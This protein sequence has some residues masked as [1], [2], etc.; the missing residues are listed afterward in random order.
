V[1]ARKPPLYRAR[2][3]LLMTE[4]TLNDDDRPMP[5]GEIK[6]FIER[7]ALSTPNLFEIVKRYNLVERRDGGSPVLSGAAMRKRIEVVVFEDYFSDFRTRN[8][9]ARSARIAI[10]F[11][12]NRPGVAEKVVR[13][14]GELV[15]DAEHEHLLQRAQAQ[16]REA[17]FSD[18]T[19]NQEAVRL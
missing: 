9:P 14:L 6:N 19:S 13:D 1:Q 4:G 8:G 3:G 5:Q 15:V 17:A 7:V 16:S 18:E 12:A 11:S 2:V 10:T